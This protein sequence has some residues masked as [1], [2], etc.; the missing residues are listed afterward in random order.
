MCFPLE[1]IPSLRLGKG[2]DP[3]LPI[4][5]NLTFIKKATQPGSL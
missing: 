4:N 5:T 1:E 2:V 3:Q